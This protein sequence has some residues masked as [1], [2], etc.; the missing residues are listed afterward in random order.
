MLGSVHVEV[1]V[2]TEHCGRTFSCLGLC[3]TES[4]AHLPV[5]TLEH[6]VVLGPPDRPICGH[7][8]MEQA[9]ALFPGTSENS[10]T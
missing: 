9:L 3:A 7:T 8:D 6:C 4:R 10:I 2:D 5:L 1:V